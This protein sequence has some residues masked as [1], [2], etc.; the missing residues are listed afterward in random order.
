MSQVFALSSKACCE[1]SS[2]SEES[3]STSKHPAAFTHCQSSLGIAEQ[4]HKRTPGDQRTQTGDWEA[5]ML[6]RASC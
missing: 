3:K 5:L 2:C 6:P 1:L 4:R